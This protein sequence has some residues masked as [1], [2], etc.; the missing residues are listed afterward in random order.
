MMKVGLL[1][2]PMG[3]SGLNKKAQQ[4]G[5]LSVTIGDHLSKPL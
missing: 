2:A 1:L 4:L 5:A 3:R